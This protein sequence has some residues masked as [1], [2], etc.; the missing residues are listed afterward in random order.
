MEERD[1]VFVLKRDGGEKERL[2]G[3]AVGLNNIPFFGLMQNC[4]SRTC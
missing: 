3:M 4:R 1:I 2:P